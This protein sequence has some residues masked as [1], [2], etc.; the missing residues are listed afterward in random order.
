MQHCKSMAGGKPAAGRA[1]APCSGATSRPR[2]P[3]RAAVKQQQQQHQPMEQQP[4]EQGVA[5][6]H[7]TLADAARVVAM[8]CAASLLLM[9]AAPMEPAMVRGGG[10]LSACGCR[11]HRACTPAC[12]DARAG[13]TACPARYSPPHHLVR[14]LPLLPC[15][16]PAHRLSSTSTRCVCGLLC[17]PLLSP[18]LCMHPG[19]RA[20]S[21][22]TP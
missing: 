11:V 4:M 6:G 20:P 21:P 8:G 22:V 10:L 2:V 15:T 19:T 17:S 3:A 7:R 16:F 13:S 12:L 9:G 1:P 5:R 14:T 18:P